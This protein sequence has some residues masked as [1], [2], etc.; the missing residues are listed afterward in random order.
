M[1]FPTVEFSARERAAGKLDRATFEKA[2]ELF[3][4][5]GS[6]RILNLFDPELMAQLAKHYR[7]R[8]ADKLIDTKKEDRRPL[9]TP[10]IAGPFADPRYHS[11]PLLFPLIQR[12]LGEDCVLGAFGSVVSF[13]GAPAQFIHRDSASLYDDFNI[14]VKLPPYALTILVPLVDANAQTGSTRVWPG[15]HREPSFD[16]AKE[17]PSESPDVP[18]GSVLMTDSRTLHGGSPNVSDRVRP[19]VYNSYHRRWYRDDGGYLQRPAVNVGVVEE[20]TMG[21]QQ[22][23]F[24]RIPLEISTLRKVQSR[25]KGVLGGLSGQKSS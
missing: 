10:T 23:P 22:R 9:F 20:L 13:P 8:Y 2:A 17:M 25:V 4:R 6:V 21:E 5:W 14:D 11:N 16:K 15:T 3:D 1:D 18:V 19:I 7:A 24:F 12:A